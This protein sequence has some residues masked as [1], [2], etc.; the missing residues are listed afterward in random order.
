M[1]ER[2]ERDS[3]E[4]NEKDTEYAVITGA[5]Q[6]LGRA[7]AFELASRNVSLI[8]VS[9]PDDGLPDLVEQLKRPGVN[10]LYYETDLTHQ[11]NMMA[12]TDWINASYKISMLINNAGIGGTKRFMD[13]DTNYLYKMIQLNVMSISLIS[14][15][16]LP[17]LVGR[18]QSYILNVSSMAAFSPMGYKTVYPA[19]KAFVHHFTMGLYEELK[20]TNVFVSVVNPGPMKTNKDVTARI[21]RQGFFARLGLLTPEKVAEISIRQLYKRDTLIMLGPGNGFNRLM[22]KLIPCRF[23]LPLLTNNVKKELVYYEGISENNKWAAEQAVP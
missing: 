22:M 18:E 16:L 7:F 2:Q 6:G 10:V 5:S 11:S 20:D 12:M 15:A 14:R 17:N 3:G 19:T 9:L 13:A 4:L 8:L 23:K 21:E 1:T